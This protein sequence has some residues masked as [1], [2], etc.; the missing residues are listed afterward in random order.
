MRDK[1]A[2]ALASKA[3]L[4]LSR[5]HDLAKTPGGL[6]HAALQGMPLHAASHASLYAL[7][8][9]MEFVHKV[10]ALTLALLLTFGT[11]AVVDP[12]FA[13]FAAA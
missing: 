13:R 10:V 8:P 3:D 11:Y 4:A 9:M 12:H 6:A 5:T 1:L 7:T 2:I